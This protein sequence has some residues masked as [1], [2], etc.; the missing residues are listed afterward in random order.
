MHIG[1][2]CLPLSS[3]P[4]FLVFLLSWSS[5]QLRTSK[6]S[7]NW[8]NRILQF[9]FIFIGLICTCHLPHHTV[10]C[11]HMHNN[12]TLAR[13][14][15]MWRCRWP[16]LRLLDTCWISCIVTSLIV[17][18]GWPLWPPQCNAILTTRYCCQGM[19]GHLLLGHAFIPNRFIWRFSLESKI[20]A[21]FLNLAL[22]M[23]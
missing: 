5:E 18:Q 11:H 20:P 10:V 1:R 15:S 23:I 16:E 19:K 2:E 6:F 4:V 14:T 7:A 21:T 13:M 12:P 9:L 3:L 22:E 8:I 17:T